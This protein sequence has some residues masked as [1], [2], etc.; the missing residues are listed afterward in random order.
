MHNP[1]HAGIRLTCSFNSHIHWDS[2]FVAAF[3]VHWRD[4][5]LLL[6][7]RGAWRLERKLQQTINKL[8]KKAV[9]L[10]AV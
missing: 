7:Y 10:R 9:L 1:I 2:K 3:D 5:I 4:D 8:D 6:F